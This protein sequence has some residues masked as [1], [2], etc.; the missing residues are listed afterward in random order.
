V[1]N[2]HGYKEPNAEEQPGWH[3]VVNDKSGRRFA[4]GRPTDYVPDLYKEAA[5]FAEHALVPEKG[6]EY[7]DEFANL[8]TLPLHRMQTVKRV[9]GEEDANEMVARGWY[10]LA[11]E[12]RGQVEW[13]RG[14][15]IGATTAFTMGHPEPKA[16]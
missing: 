12:P 3:L 16:K 13:E 11:I 8:D 5:W 15:V 1:L 10:I 4:G 6:P 9:I 14:E 2:S 7:I